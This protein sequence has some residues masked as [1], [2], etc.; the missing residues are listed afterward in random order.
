MSATDMLLCIFVA[1]Q[2]RWHCL[3]TKS[4]GGRSGRRRP[5]GVDVEMKGVA[6]PGMRRLTSATWMRQHGRLCAVGED[7]AGREIEQEARGMVNEGLEVVVTGGGMGWKESSNEGCTPA[8]GMSA[9][10][11]VK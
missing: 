9:S 10:R 1:L 3:K 2:R 6:Q 7:A 4:T 5:E 11:M 8:Q